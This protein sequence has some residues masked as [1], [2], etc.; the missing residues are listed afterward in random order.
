MIKKSQKQ[1]P[2]D[3][4][5]TK[6]ANVQA[7]LKRLSDTAADHFDTNPDEIN[8]GNVGDIGDIE[9]KL[10]YLCDVVFKEGEHALD[11]KA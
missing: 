8:W 1:D 5:I 4:Y 10:K 2:V 11:N 6:S 9:E 7:M 3:A